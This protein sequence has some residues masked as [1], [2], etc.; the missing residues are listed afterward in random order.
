M[1]MRIRPE[2]V[3]GDTKKLKAV[4]F[5]TGTSPAH[6]AWI[7]KDRSEPGHIGMPELAAPEKGE[8]CFQVFTDDVVRLMERVLA[9]DGK[10]WDL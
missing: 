7:T 9:W 3:A 8:T 1:I 10:S 4:S 5:G 6:R 2:L